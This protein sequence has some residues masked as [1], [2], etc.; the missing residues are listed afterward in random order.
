MDKANE[1]QHEWKS[2]VGAGEAEPSVRTF[3]TQNSLSGSIPAS[4]G[5]MA[6]L[7]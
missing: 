6:K 5:A 2:T 1:Y 3:L 7:Q 4:F